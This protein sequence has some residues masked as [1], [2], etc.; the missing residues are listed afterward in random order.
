MENNMGRKEYFFKSLIL[1]AI[2][3]GIFGVG[4]LDKFLILDKKL[5]YILFF[6]GYLLYSF[7]SV[8][9]TS[10]YGRNVK[11]TIMNSVFPLVLYLSIIIWSSNKVS[12][13]IAVLLMIVLISIELVYEGG[14]IKR[15]LRK[16]RRYMWTSFRVELFIFMIVTII[17]TGL[18][19][20][21]SGTQ[22]GL[23]TVF[24]EDVSDYGEEEYREED[25]LQNNIEVI[26]KVEMWNE[27]D[28]DTK[29]ESIEAVFRVESRYLGEEGIP[30]LKITKTDEYISGYYDS[31]QDMI[32]L[33]KEIFDGDDGYL[34]LGSVCHEMRHRYQYMQCELYEKIK[35]DSDYEVYRNMICWSV[36]KVYLE[37][38]ENYVTV[39]ESLENG[40][41]D[42]YGNQ[43]IEIDADY[44]EEKAIEEYKEKIAE[45][46]K[47]E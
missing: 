23:T 46:L 29:I 13:I 12:L 39:S 9:A 6:A 44:Y 19:A 18:F 4:F 35:N 8:R 17:G 33:S 14:S 36:E 27:L 41:I 40:S 16:I 11:N 2:I 22:G 20:Y 30:A 47:N 15:R 37:E 45:Y 31:N 38:F 21:I 28:D 24:K 34:V 32:C 5:N 43:W 26:S 10:R 42:D 1:S 7:V 3:M 25:K